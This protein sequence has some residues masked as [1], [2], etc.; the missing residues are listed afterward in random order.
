MDNVIHK[1]ISI[2]NRSVSQDDVLKFIYNPDTNVKILN[3]MIDDC[4]RT[5]VITK[6]AEKAFCIF[7][8][9]TV[10]RKR[11]QIPVFTIPSSGIRKKIVSASTFHE[12]IKD[13]FYKGIADNLL[14]L[15]NEAQ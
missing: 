5:N 7:H 10:T 12:D 11:N 1:F 13:T 2:N 3:D 9:I 15:I 4:L 8:L 6:D 14:I